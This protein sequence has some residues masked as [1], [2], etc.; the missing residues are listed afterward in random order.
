M[1]KLTPILFVDAIEPSLPFWI[2]R[3]GFEKTAEVPHG[4]RLGFVILQQG[5]LEVMLQ[6]WASIEGDAPHLARAPRGSS[7]ALYLDVEDFADTV[8]RLEGCDVV[9]PPRKTF[10]GADEIWVRE[11][12]GHLVGFAYFARG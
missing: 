10:Y 1:K 12:G 5:A 3:L 8:Q 9:V 11:P 6:T 2:E 7:H 4:D